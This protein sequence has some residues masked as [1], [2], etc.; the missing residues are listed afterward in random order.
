[1]S[2]AGYSIRTLKFEPFP[3]V[4]VPHNGSLSDE[5]IS[6]SPMLDARR[7][8]PCVSFVVLEYVILT[9]SSNHSGEANLSVFSDG[10][11]KVPIG[12]FANL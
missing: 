9:Y 4:I 1:V 5:R 3:S 2:T 6:N 8:R 11:Q 12:G 7:L 10:L